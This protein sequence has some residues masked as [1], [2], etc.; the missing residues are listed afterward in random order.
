VLSAGD[1]MVIVTR[2]TNDAGHELYDVATRSAA[3]STSIDRAGLDLGYAQGAA[4]DYVRKR[5]RRS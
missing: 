5:A 4:E 2:T 1:G 3:A